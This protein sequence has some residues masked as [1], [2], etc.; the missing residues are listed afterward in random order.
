VEKYCIAREDTDDNI[1]WRTRFAHWIT[2]ATDTQSE[3]LILIACTLHQWLQVRASILRFTYSACPFK[4]FVQ[5]V[6]V[7]CAFSGECV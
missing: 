4:P 3:Y 2:K 6:I 1:T 7:L 5:S